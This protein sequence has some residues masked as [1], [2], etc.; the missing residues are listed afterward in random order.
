MLHDSYNTAHAG[1]GTRAEWAKA[2][3]IVGVRVEA[4]H[5]AQCFIVVNNTPTCGLRTAYR[6]ADAAAAEAVA[7]VARRLLMEDDLGMH[8]WDS[9][10]DT[11]YRST[12]K[13]LHPEHHDSEDFVIV[14]TS[15]R[16]QD[17]PYERPSDDEWA[18]VLADEFSD[19]VAV[20]GAAAL[21]AR[22]AEPVGRVLSVYA[23]LGA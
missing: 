11:V 7:D 10:C 6:V 4:A 21:A 23:A 9:F 16:H 18:A 19:V 8:M 2:A 12:V 15:E 5:L 1:R 14:S 20:E 22:L 13:V 17:C 3:G